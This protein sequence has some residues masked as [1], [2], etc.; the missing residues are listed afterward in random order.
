M[1]DLNCPDRNLLIIVG[2]KPVYIVQSGKKWVMLPM[3]IR[4]PLT[5]LFLRAWPDLRERGPESAY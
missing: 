4:L 5:T 2:R 1:N 3:E